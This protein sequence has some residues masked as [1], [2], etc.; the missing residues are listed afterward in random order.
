MT[1]LLPFGLMLGVSRRGYYL[2]TFLLVVV[3][4][5]GYGLGLTV[6]QIVERATGG[7]GLAVHFFR[8]PWIL[9]AR[10]TRRG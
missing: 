5:V 8:V 4:G 3:L 9:T 7:W 1:R 6:L 2:G 10:G